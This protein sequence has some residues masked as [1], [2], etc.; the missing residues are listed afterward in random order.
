MQSLDCLQGA[1]ADRV[2]GFAEASAAKTLAARQ[3]AV[4]AQNHAALMNSIQK[5]LA[6][7]PLYS[8]YSEAITSTPYGG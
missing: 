7:P 6:P 1:I 2:P 4:I 8:P 3:H 5:D